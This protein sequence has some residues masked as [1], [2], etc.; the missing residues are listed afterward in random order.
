MNLFHLMDLSEERLAA[1]DPAFNEQTEVVQAILKA[2]GAL[3]YRR[4]MLNGALH[5]QV[6]ALI[7]LAHEA[8]DRIDVTTRRA[9]TL[10]EYGYSTK[11][12]EYLDK[13]VSAQILHSKHDRAEG[14]VSLGPVIRSYLA[15]A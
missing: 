6:A 11:I 5:K 13:A 10:H 7:V 3:P 1:N 12:I 14:E 4:A 2:V 8:G 15:Q 9:G